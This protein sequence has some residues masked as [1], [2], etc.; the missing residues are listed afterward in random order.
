MSDVSKVTN[1]SAVFKDAS[2]E[3]IL[4][5][6]LKGTNL[7][8]E[9]QN[10]VVVIKSGQPMSVQD[11]LK[12]VT[13]KGVVKDS[14]GGML[15]GVTVVL[16]GTTTGVATGISGDF[17][18]TNPERDSVTLLFSFVGMKTKEVKWRGQTELSRS[19]GRRYERN[20]GSGD[21]G[22]SGD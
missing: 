16:K 15:P 10:R 21:Y 13:V 4:D 7:Y 6:L 8:Y 19:V 3:A 1:V 9:I 17:V 2:L 14:R 18:I 11:S 5:M 22:V 20:G 12:G